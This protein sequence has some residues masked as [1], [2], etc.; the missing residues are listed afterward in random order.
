VVDHHHGCVKNGRGIVC[1]EACHGVGRATIFESLSDKCLDRMLGTNCTSL[2]IP[3]F[4][5]FG[6]M[7]YA[8]AIL[9]KD[10]DTCHGGHEDCDYCTYRAM[11]LERT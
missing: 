6:V 8:G 2:T 7:P 3:R 9:G 10:Y 4:P 5:G 11:L 1:S